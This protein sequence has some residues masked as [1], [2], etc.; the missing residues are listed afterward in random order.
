MPGPLIRPLIKQIKNPSFV[1]IKDLGGE[2][3]TSILATAMR[4]IDLGTVPAILTCYNAQRLRWFK[5]SRDFPRRWYLHDKLD[6][7][8]FAYELLVNGKEQAG[9][10]KSSG[11]SWFRNTDSDQYEVLEHSVLGRDGE[12]LTLLLPENSML[13]A[14]YDPDVFPKRYGADGISFK[15]R[16]R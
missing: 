16:P 1:S 2:F 3:E 14:R 13:D 8:T 6:D 7:E 9:P 11:E 10:R 4:L 15:R 12:V 5:F